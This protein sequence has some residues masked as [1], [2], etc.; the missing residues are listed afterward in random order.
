[1]QYMKQCYQLVA[2]IWL[3]TCSTKIDLHR[4]GC[5]RNFTTF[6]WMELYCTKLL[7][8][9]IKF[10]CSILHCL[11]PCLTFNVSQV[12]KPGAKSLVAADTE[13]MGSCFPH[14]TFTG[15]N[16][17]EKL[18]SKSLRTF[19]Y[20]TYKEQKVN[21]YDKVWYWTQKLWPEHG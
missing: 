17:L 11:W 1:M 15:S 7:C 9:C 18:L 19:I 20:K 16:C 5:N 12:V 2:A 4:S 21:A 10:N 14:L 3:Y 13:V 8:R 6:I